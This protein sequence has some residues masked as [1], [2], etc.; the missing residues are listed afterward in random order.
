MGK[1]IYDA[2]DVLKVITKKGAKFLFKALLNARN[3]AIHKG[4][5]EHCLFVKEVVVGKRIRMKKPDIR[6]KGSA[7]IRKKPAS[8]ATIYL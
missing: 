2:F 6:A 5:N 3:N 8:S 7:G 4:A 1:H